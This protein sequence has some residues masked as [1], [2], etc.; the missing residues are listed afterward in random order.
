M[1]ISPLCSLVIVFLNVFHVLGKPEDHVS[2]I[3]LSLMLPSPPYM[4]LV[5]NVQSPLFK[6]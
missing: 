6:P 2:E 5:E 1:D 4:S 3:K